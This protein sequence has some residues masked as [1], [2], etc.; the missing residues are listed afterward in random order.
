MYDNH[1]C[2]YVLL[3]LIKRLVDLGT[4]ENQTNLPDVEIDSINVS[5]NNEN[6]FQTGLNADKLRNS[7]LVSTFLG[8]LNN[9]IQFQEE[10]KI[11]ILG[12]ILNYLLNLNRT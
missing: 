11:L 12:V 8:R 3:F 10:S 5:S 7:M 6:R 9:Q 2:W 4:K 1:Q